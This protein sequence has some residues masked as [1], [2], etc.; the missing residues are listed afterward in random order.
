M[1]QPK[2]QKPL[3]DKGGTVNQAMQRLTVG[4]DPRYDANLFIYDCI[5]SA[6]QAKILHKAKLLSAEELHRVL[7]SLKAFYEDAVHQGVTIPYQLED[8]HTLLESKLV[9]ACGDSGKKIHTGRSR[10]DQILVTTRLFLRDKITVILSEL[11]GIADLFA[12]QYAQYKDCFLPGYT[13][14]QPAMPSSVGMYMHAFYEWTLEIITSGLSLLAFVN[15]N[16]LGAA[17]GFGSSLPLDRSFG[18]SLM[19]FDAVQRSFIDIQNSRGRYEEQFL[20]WL[21]NSAAL[22]EKFAWDMELF[23]TKE[24]GFIRLDDALTTGSSIM[25]Q[26]KNPDIIELLRGRA[27]VQRS[28]VTQIQAVT[29]KLPSHYH[30]DLALTK[31]PLF[32]GIENISYVLQMA[33]V[34]I[35]AISFRT[36]VL[37]QSRIDNPEIFATYAAYRKVKDGMPFRDAYTCTAQEVSQLQISHEG[38]AAESAFIQQEVDHGMQAALHEYKDLEAAVCEYRDRLAQVSHAIFS[39]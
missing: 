15:K 26:K 37:E 24:F 12:A 11:L 8:C 25:P 1:N 5:G 7:Q 10:N 34:L 9:E 39:V 27:A 19:G 32:D 36:D 2:L 23:F 29:A 35:P 13:H 20:F 3:W 4:D 21:S 31:K 38:Y 18:A 14:L 30:R 33:T 16:P 6:A 28:F 22:F 17:A